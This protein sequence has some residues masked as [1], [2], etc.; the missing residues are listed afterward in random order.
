MAV[1]PA[2]IVKG[3]FEG[4]A[5]VCFI[6]PLILSRSF[7]NISYF[8]YWFQSRRFFKPEGKKIF[9]TTWRAARAIKLNLNFHSGE[10]D[11]RTKEWQESWPEAPSV[12]DS[13]NTDVREDRREARAAV[14]VYKWLT[15]SVVSNDTSSCASSQMFW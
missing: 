14:L 8:T 13:A 1:A 2:K 6:T 11:A 10:C 9:R 15:P 4:F 7:V 5:I 3:D 12:G